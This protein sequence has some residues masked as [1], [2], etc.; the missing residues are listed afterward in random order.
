M[1]TED[2]AYRIVSQDEFQSSA[3]GR[4]SFVGLLFPSTLVLEGADLSDSRFDRC[5]FSEATIRGVDFSG[6][7]FVDCK[8]EPVRF[9]SCRFS[10]AQLRNCAWFD[11]NRKK[12][13]TFAF[14]DMQDVEALKCNFAT[15]MFERCDLYGLGAVDSS[16][17]GAQF[18]QSTFS[19]TISRRSALTKA[20]FERCN[21]SFADLSGLVLQNCEFRSCKCSEASFIDSDFGNATMLDCSLD[22]VEWTR[23]RLRGADLR[24]SDLSGLNLSVL[25][26]YAGMRI[27]ESEQSEILRQIGVHVHR[28]RDDK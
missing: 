2:S 18:H 6:S 15:T 13:C 19:K 16:F 14:C 23:A 25:S 5:L 22:R 9:A 17:R 20:S 28:S 1:A 11:A 21:I 10:R 3:A 4:R 12:A 26:D 24:G 7:A 8:F 27:S